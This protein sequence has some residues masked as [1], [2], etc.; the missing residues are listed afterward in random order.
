MLTACRGGRDDGGRCGDRTG[1]TTGVPS[2]VPLLVAEEPGDRND[3]GA[4]SVPGSGVARVVWASRNAILGASARCWRWRRHRAGVA[5]AVHPPGKSYLNRKQ[6]RTA[7]QP[8]RH[9]RDNLCEPGFRE[10]RGA[11][12]MHVAETGQ[13]RLLLNDLGDASVA[14]S[15]DAAFC[16][17]RSWPWQSPTGQRAGPGRYRADHGVA[18]ARPHVAPH[19]THARKAATV[20]GPS[21]PACRR[22]ASVAGGVP[23][24][25]DGLCA[26][27]RG[28]AAGGAGERL[29]RGRNKKWAS[30]K[31]QAT[32]AIQRP[33][34]IA[35]PK[36]GG[37]ACRGGPS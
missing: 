23:A 27:R 21:R 33:P 5:S 13:D 26:R 32:T 31:V 37:S 7:N 28:R 15:S 11:D 29:R 14:P 24:D 20:L 18:P 25:L 34:A 16:R 8:A 22:R 9:P 19:E 2:A 30:Q 3:L 36:Q 6:P 35:A 1:P 10:R 12:T 4:A 17:P